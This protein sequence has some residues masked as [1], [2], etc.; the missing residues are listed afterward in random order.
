LGDCLIWTVS[1]KL[2]KLPTFLGHSFPQL[3]LR[4]NISK[5]GLGYIL[6]DFFTNSSGHPG[7]AASS[8]MEA[9][10]LEAKQCRQLN[11]RLAHCFDCR[12]TNAETIR[13]QKFF[14]SMHWGPEPILRS[15]FTTPALKKL[16]PQPIA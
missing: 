1:W 11:Q 16:S 4:I 3:K 10:S 14:F 9:V 6:G 12:I 13:P 7:L 5:K 2:Q 8:K 15:R